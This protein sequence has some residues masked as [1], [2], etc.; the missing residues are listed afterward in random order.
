V[1]LTGINWPK[2]KRDVFLL[3]MLVGVLVVFLTAVT[4]NISS[5]LHFQDYSLSS[6]VILFIL[7][8]LFAFCGHIP[9][10]IATLEKENYAL[11]RSLIFIQ[12]WAV[13]YVLSASIL[14]F[15]GSDNFWLAAVPVAYAGMLYIFRIVFNR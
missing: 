13:G 15:L 5:K 9:I 3:G 8:F 12:G 6:A 2:A 7:I 14:L 1:K 4:L 11:D 10:T